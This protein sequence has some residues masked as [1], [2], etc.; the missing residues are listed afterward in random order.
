MNTSESGYESQ[1]EN[2]PAALRELAKNG[3]LDLEKHG[4]IAVVKSYSEI[5]N[6]EHRL[7]KELQVHLLVVEGP[8]LVLIFKKPVDLH[9]E[10]AT[11]GILALT[12]QRWSGYDGPVTVLTKE[13][14]D[15][16]LFSSHD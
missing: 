16:R 7:L 2:V 14:C 15:A 3:S 8:K 13:W 1:A 9:I 11:V 12:E 10:E 5:E 4:F 6:L